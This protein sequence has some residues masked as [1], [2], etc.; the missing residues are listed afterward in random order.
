MH[1]WYLTTGMISKGKGK[2]PSFKGHECI[3]NNV[4]IF[5]LWSISAI[6]VVKTNVLIYGNYLYFTKQRNE[7]L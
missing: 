5:A 6:N 4:L 3:Q 7:E 2:Y 1:I